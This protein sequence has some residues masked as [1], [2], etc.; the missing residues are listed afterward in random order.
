MT[1]EAEGRQVPELLEA[2]LSDWIDFIF[3][4][5]PDELAIYAD[6]DECTTFYV[7]QEATLDDLVKRLA[8]AGFEPVPNYE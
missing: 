5:T 4:G 8:A 2:V 6:H 7:R 1:L 3:V